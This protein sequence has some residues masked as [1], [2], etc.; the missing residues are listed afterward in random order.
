MKKTILLTIRFL[1]VIG[2]YI[3]LTFIFLD[4]TGQQNVIDSFRQQLKKNISYIF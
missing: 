4:L 3:Q 1:V 2:I